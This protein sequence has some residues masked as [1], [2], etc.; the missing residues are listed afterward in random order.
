M[1]WWRGR[2]RK[3]NNPTTGKQ[4]DGEEVTERPK[5]KEKGDVRHDGRTGTNG[6]EWEKKNTDWKSIKIQKTVC[7]TTLSE[8]ESLFDISKVDDCN[9]TQ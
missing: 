6:L 5:F 7:V 1:N 8:V 4:R 2:N 3:K 9:A